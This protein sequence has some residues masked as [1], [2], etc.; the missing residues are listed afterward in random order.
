MT[1]LH[2][3]S[4]SDLSRMIRRRE[5][6]SA[7]LTDHFIARIEKHDPKINAVVARDFDGARKAMLGN[8]VNALPAE[9]YR[10]LA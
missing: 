9:R 3:R 6:G 7:E 10:T 2:F 8:L 4:A 1:D 5:I